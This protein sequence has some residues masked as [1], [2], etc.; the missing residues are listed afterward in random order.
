[1]AKKA[2]R[3]LSADLEPAKPLLTAAKVEPG[4]KRVVKPAAREDAPF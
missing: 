1:M 3:P 4:K 2:A